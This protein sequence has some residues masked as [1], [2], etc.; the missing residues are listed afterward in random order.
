MP[1]EEVMKLLETSPSGLNEEEILKRQKIYGPNKIEEIRKLSPIRL[2]F[3]QFQN[4]LNYILILAAIISLVGESILD[5]VVIIIIIFIN[6]ILGFIQEY[7]SEQALEALKELSAPKTVVMRAG[8]ERKVN[9][10][11]LVPGDIVILATGD[12]VP[13]DIRLFAS[14]RMRVEESILTGEPGSEEKITAELPE[15]TPLVD[16]INMVYSGTSITGGRGSGVVV[17]NGMYT[18][19]GKIAREISEAGVEKTPLQKRISS[20]A[21]Y[22]AILAIILASSQAILAFL[23]GLPLYDVLLFA[24]ASAISSIPEG[25]LAVITIVLVIGVRIMAK[26]NAIIRNLQAVETLGSATVICTDKT[27]TLTKNEMT[28]RALYLNGELI[29]VTGEGYTPIGNFKK[30]GAIIEPQE[31]QHLQLLLKAMALCNDA[32]LVSENGRYSI[33][34][35][36]TEGALVV[37]AAKG[38]IDKEKEERQTPRIDE[39]PFESEL[40]CMTTVHDFAEKEKH[41]Y[42]KGS[43]ERIIS[44]CNEIYINNKAIEITDKLRKQVLDVSYELAAK[45]YRV[46]GISY[47]VVGSATYRLAREDCGKDLIFLG[48]VAMVDPPRKEAIE[49]V[50]KCKKAGIKVVMI[51]GDHRETARAIAQEMGIMTEKDIILEGRELDNIPE[52]EFQKIVESVKVYART[53]PRHK[54]RIVKALKNRGHIVAMGGDGVNDA[55][56]LKEANIGI[57]MGISGT[58]IAKETSDMVL[59]DDN[60]A[61]IVGAVEEGR[62]TFLNLR[63]VV[64]YLLATNIAE[65]IVLFSTLLLGFP[66]PFLPL[67]ILWINLVTDGICD[68][69]LAVEPRYRDVLKDP[70]RPPKER[71]V[72]RGVL[73]QIAF[74]ASIMAIGTVFVYYLGIQ[75]LGPL[76]IF[77]GYEIPRTMTFYT[78]IFFQLFNALNVRS[79]EYSLFKIG[80]TSN[81]YLAIGL[82]FSFIL[83]ISIVYVPFFQQ[84]FEITP[85]PL[86]GWLIVL[87]VSSSAL[88][89]EEIRKALAPKLFS[90]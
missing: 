81:K 17:A 57:A 3:K 53:E 74:L 12:R 48:L 67:Q 1:T 52:E 5:A 51:T 60:F 89:I 70:P 64:L 72:S 36:P 20:L 55:P 90:K 73:Y 82:I 8:K 83:N 18:E 84:L 41:V 7:R 58:Q 66:L 14:V 77:E 39:I 16:R 28:V 43:P 25:L 24:L 86:G 27:G 22:L 40:A 50:A 19:I 42:A 26:R 38:G 56:A 47:R 65:D 68:K 71:I 54:L 78:I 80:I 37:A 35:D 85:L 63:R 49:A 23:R 30:N 87:L 10:D 46:L 44:L 13:A 75:S 34:G 29:E 2:F 79:R 32:Y 9:T 88:I 76:I 11:E 21:I 69:T 59:A 62:T 61:S 31:N 33:F 45:G 4:A 6:A 15:D